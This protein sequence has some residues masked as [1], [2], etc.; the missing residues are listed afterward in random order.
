L[1]VLSVAT[2]QIAHAHSMQCVSPRDHVSLQDALEAAVRKKACLWLDRLYFLDEPLHLP[3][4]SWISGPGGLVARDEARIA[5]AM[6]YARDADRIRI[7]NITLDGNADRNG[8]DYGLWIV[9]GDGH[10]IDGIQV[11]D[12]A[13]AGIALEE[14]RDYLV[15]RPKLLRCG[16]ARRVSGLPGTDDHGMMIFS[17]GGIDTVG[18]RVIA[19]V[20]DRARRKGLAT[21]SR[22]AGIV[23]DLTIVSAVVRDCGLGGLYLGAVAGMPPGRNITILSPHLSRNYVNIQLVNIDGCRIDNGVSEDAGFAGL[24]ISEGCRSVSVKRFTDQN[25]GLHGIFCSSDGSSNSGLE[26]DNVLISGANTTLAGFG[27]GIVLGNTVHSIVRHARVLDIGGRMT[28]GLVETGTSDFNLVKD[29]MIRSARGR[30]YQLKG[31]HSRIVR[32]N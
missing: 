21:Y 9:G 10:H 2:A 30:N 22:R 5:G 23:R 14:V 24:D 13:Q 20:I 25:S 31:P 28:H 8:C 26:L 27:A 17:T 1:F 11:R 4:D 3:S 7:S 12:T 29:S 16:R 15:V 32:P 6:L 19:P 18:G